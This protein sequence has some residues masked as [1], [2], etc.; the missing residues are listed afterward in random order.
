MP[1]NYAVEARIH[2]ML[3]DNGVLEVAHQDFI[4]EFRAGLFTEQ[5]ALAHIK[6]ARTEKPHR[7]VIS[8]TEDDELFVSAFGP[9]RTLT[10]QG[11]V[12][13]K[14]GEDRAKEIAA[15]FGT[16]LGSTK[17]GT[18]PATIKSAANGHD[19]NPFVGLRDPRTGEI[20]PE[21]MK[22]VESLLKAVGAAKCAAIAKSAGLRLDGTPI[23]DQ[24]R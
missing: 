9:Q 10:A 16:T 14:F 22:A 18:V 24:Y 5:S 20:I 11:E 23:P 6:A 21:K 17:P 3:A 1:I 2:E 19:K 8:G 12:I 13:K 15:Q 7:W 4:D